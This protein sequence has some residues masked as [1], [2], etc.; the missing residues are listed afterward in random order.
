MIYEA[1]ARDMLK[2]CSAVV[3]AADPPGLREQ[4]ESALTFACIYHI[5]GNIGR[6]LNLAVFRKSAKFNTPLIFPAIT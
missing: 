5:V 2:A 3:V 4:S 6:A 1:C